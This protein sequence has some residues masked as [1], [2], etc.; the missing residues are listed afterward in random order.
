M[1]D[2]TLF[3]ET[4]CKTLQKLKLKGITQNSNYIKNLEAACDQKKQPVKVV[5]SKKNIIKIVGI[6]ATIIG[7]IATLIIIKKKK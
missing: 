2:F 1:E 3:S 5:V 7:L 4:P 6:S